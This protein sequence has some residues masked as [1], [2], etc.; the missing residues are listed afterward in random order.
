[1][2]LIQS[3]LKTVPLCRPK[4]AK[5]GYIGTE[6]TY[7]PIGDIKAEI[8]PVSALTQAEKFGVTISRGILIFCELGT[9]IRERD[10]VRWQSADYS[11]KGVMQYNNILRVE[12][13]KVQ[14]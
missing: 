13:E 6:T 10:R 5:S 12:A 9:D 7:D 3:R 2:R 11:V 4:T 8:Q 14:P 1:M